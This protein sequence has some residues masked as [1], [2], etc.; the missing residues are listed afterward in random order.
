M[1]N[2]QV[3][4]NRNINQNFE[5]TVNFLST[6]PEIIESKAEITVNINLGTTISNLLDLLVEKIGISFIKIKEAI[7]SND[8]IIFGDP[9]VILMNGRNISAYD[10]LET[11]IKQNDDITMFI[12]IGGG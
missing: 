11:I 8:D 7:E 3:L 9:I 5:V 2:D 4:N 6:L 1:T 12:P 10:G